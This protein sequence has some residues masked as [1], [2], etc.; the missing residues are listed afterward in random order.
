[1]SL[2][3][4]RSDYL[5]TTCSTR[6]TCMPSVL[7]AQHLTCR[8]T[9]RVGPWALQRTGRTDHR[10]A[11]RRVRSAALRPDPGTPSGRTRLGPWKRGPGA[12]RRCSV[13][14]LRTGQ[15]LL[16][17]CLPLTGVRFGSPIEVRLLIIYNKCDISVNVLAFWW[18]FLQLEGCIHYFPEMV[19]FAWRAR[20]DV[21]SFRFVVRSIE[22]W[23]I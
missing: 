23:R 11:L 9:H 10:I 1:M 15:F 6:S 4:S 8:A 7:R 12:F 14:R 20:A 22:L 21:R 16:P 19:W 13:F 18:L 3:R 17:T 5:L 2:C